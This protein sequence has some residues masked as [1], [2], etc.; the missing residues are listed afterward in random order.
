MRAV[1]IYGFCKL[2]LNSVDEVFQERQIVKTFSKGSVFPSQGLCCTWGWQAAE[3]S[4]G[5][6]ILGIKLFFV[7]PGLKK[8][9][10]RKISSTLIS[11]IMDKISAKF[12]I[13]FR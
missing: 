1:G 2:S 7:Y 5:Y 6:L 3:Q 10:G 4:K 12:A 11:P 8:L 9:Y 13:L